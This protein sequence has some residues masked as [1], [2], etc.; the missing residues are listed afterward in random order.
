M[1]RA[2]GGFNVNRQVTSD[3]TPWGAVGLDSKGDVGHAMRPRN[4]IPASGIKATT[5]QR[6]RGT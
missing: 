4:P 1:G 5:A 6:R 2:T 3:W